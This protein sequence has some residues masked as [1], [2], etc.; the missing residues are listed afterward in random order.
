MFQHFS[1]KAIKAIMLAQEEARRLGHDWCGAE[2]LLLGLIREGTSVAARE[3]RLRGVFLRDC[4]LEVETILS[5]GSGSVPVEIPFTPR[6][7]RILELTWDEARL[8]GH[9]EITSEHLLLG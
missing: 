3:L 7:K 5:R 8:L 9:S 1:T 2:H 4:R 6:A